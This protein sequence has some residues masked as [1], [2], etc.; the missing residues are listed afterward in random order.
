MEAEGRI[1]GMSKWT[2]MELS[3]RTDLVVEWDGTEGVPATCR[4][5]LD[6]LGMRGLLPPAITIT[7]VA[8]SRDVGDPERTVRCSVHWMAGVEGHSDMTSPSDAPE[9]PGD[10]EVPN[11]ERFPSAAGA[12]GLALLAAT[13]LGD[14]HRA[15]T[16]ID[17]AMAMF[18]RVAGLDGMKKALPEVERRAGFM[19]MADAY[20]SVRDDVVAGRW[21]L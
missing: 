7:D 15:Q 13:S 14:A 20:D 5:A 18:T 1:D 21:Q 19:D 12:A 4:S 2:L 8:T 16:R 11:S 10:A 17:I 3:G 6:E 9:A